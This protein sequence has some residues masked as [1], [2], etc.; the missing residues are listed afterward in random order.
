M[1]SAEN[2][3]YWKCS[4]RQYSTQ[5]ALLKH[6][7]TKNDWVIELFE[8]SGSVRRKLQSTVSLDHPVVVVT[9]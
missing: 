3:V 2:A 8:F 7:N 5:M 6:Q 1:Y 4:G 9:V